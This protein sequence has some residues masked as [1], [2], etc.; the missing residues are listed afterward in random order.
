MEYR[1]L[2]QEWKEFKQYRRKI[3]PYEDDMDMVQAIS[4]DPPHFFP[5]YFWLILPMLGGAFC[6]L[7][8]LF[9]WFNLRNYGVLLVFFPL[10]VFWVALLC[11]CISVTVLGLFQRDRFMAISPEGVTIPRFLR[12]PV[13]IAWREIRD[14]RMQTNLVNT[15]VKL[16][17]LHRTGKT[18]TDLELFKFPYLR[19]LGKEFRI[20]K[21]LQMYIRTQLYAEE[22]IH[23][24]KQID[25][26]MKEQRSSKRHI[27]EIII[28]IVLIAGSWLTGW[29]LGLSLFP[30]F[31]VLGCMVI[32][33]QVLMRR[34][35]SYTGPGIIVVICILIIIFTILFSPLF[36]NA[37]G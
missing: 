20:I 17:I 14:I 12:S 32:I 35:K 22:P 4:N 3:E 26:L 37:L 2:T 31:I 21:I 8:M 27:S 36:P 1:E 25:R 19:G 18:T 23:I 9:L 28:P 11:I 33:S 29:I 16:I 30:Q 5:W 7:P 24:E 13:F 15:H 34:H 10:D 6:G